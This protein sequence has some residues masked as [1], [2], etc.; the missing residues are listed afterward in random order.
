MS[1]IADALSLFDKLVARAAATGGILTC[2]QK[3]ALDQA[4]ELHA[5]AQEEIAKVSITKKH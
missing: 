1:T 3:V 5:R 4:L 2:K